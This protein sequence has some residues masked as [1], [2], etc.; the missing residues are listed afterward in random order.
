MGNKSPEAASHA[1]ELASEG[2]FSLVVYDED[3]AAAERAAGR[4]GIPAVGPLGESDLQTA[5]VAVICT[6]TD[7][8]VQYL[9]R[10]LAAGV[11]VIVCEKP[12]SNDLREL[13]AARRAYRR[14]ESRVL[15]NYTR[16]FLPA[17]A[18]LRS[19]MAG[20]AR[21]ERVRAVAVRYQRGFLNN[22]SHAFDLLQM[23]LG[24]DIS[25]ARVAIT[26]STADE[27]P[28]DPTLS[29]FGAWNGAELSVLGLPRV[30]FSLF[31]LNMFSTHGGRN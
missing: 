22:A 16:H 15:V 26:S 3:P 29:L 17:Y 27:F 21:G 1:G 14:G 24:W 9:K 19:K 10:L 28:D 8:H 20:L 23:L 18:A 4:F 6:P 25:T 2:H 5:D 12:V 31:E 30:K 11:P 7:T 13:R